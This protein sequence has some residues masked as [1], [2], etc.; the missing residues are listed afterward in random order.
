MAAAGQSLAARPLAMASM[1]GL[2]AVFFG[3]VSVVLPAWFIFAVLL[4]PVLAAVTLV[5]PEYALLA[6]MA[7]V[8]GLIHPGFVPRIPVL[9]GSLAA[10]DATLLMLGLYALWSLATQPPLAPAAPV[11]GARW[12]GAAAGL[13]SLCLVI[14]VATSLQ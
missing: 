13:F 5:R 1:L 2:L 14:A 10:A 4:V 7:L 6:C 11:A 8:C 9:G 3:L 12:M